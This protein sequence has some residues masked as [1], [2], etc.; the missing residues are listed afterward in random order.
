M[1]ILINLHSYQ[2]LI[3]SLSANFSE[4]KTMFSFFE[5]RVNTIRLYI[6][7]SALLVI[8]LKAM[9]TTQ[10]AFDPY[11]L[12]G[13]VAGYFLV[14]LGISYF[15]AGA[16]EFMAEL[17]GLGVGLI[18]VWL[19]ILLWGNNF[20][21]DFTSGYQILSVA[22]V[23]LFD[24]RRIMFWFSI[25]AG[26]TLLCAAFF[27]ISPI[28]QMWVFVAL[29]LAVFLV[30]NFIVASRVNTRSKLEMDL[31]H[32]L[33]IQ[34]AAIESNT[35]AILLVN[36]EGDYIKGNV[37][38]LQMW[39]VSA[40]MILQNLQAETE[41]QALSLV[42]DPKELSTIWAHRE[43]GLG[44]GELRQIAFKDGRMIELYWRPMINNDELIGRLWFFRD[45][46]AR[47]LH[48]TQLMATERQLRHQNEML[49]EF[50]SSFATNAGKLEEAF[51]EITSVSSELLQVDTVGV[52]FLDASK[53]EMRLELQFDRNEN[54][55]RGNVAVKLADHPDFFASLFK[56]RVFAVADTLRVESTAGFIEGKYSGKASALMHAQI[57]ARGECI[58]V[59][60]FECAGKIR[61][62]TL[63]EQN[64]AASLAD[65]VSV[66]L[67][68]EEKQNAQERL[69][70]SL[71]VLQAIFDLSETGIIVEDNDH[72]IL[73]YN[74]LY[75]KI[76][77]M[78]REFVD[79]QPYKVLVD[80]CLS[81]LKNSVAYEEGLEKLKVRPGMEYAGIMEFHDGRFIERYSKAIN[82][83]GDLMGRVWFYLD[84]TDRKRKENELINRNF[85][86]D[87]FVY[88]A[89][90]DLKA[91]LNSI[92]GLI[93]LIREEQEIDSILRYISMMDKSVKKL[94]EFIKQ[95][96]Q[97]S[98]DVRLKVVRKPIDFKEMVDDILGD[99][100]FME[101]A[102]RLAI[103]IEVE[104]QGAFYSDPVRLGIIMAN[105]L[106]NAIK[107]QDLKKEKST[108]RIHIV[109]DHAEAKCTFSDNGLGIKAEH[110]EKIFDLFF[111]ASIQASGTGLGLYITHNAVQKLGGK[112]V[113]DSEPGIG[114][115]F[116]LQLPNLAD[117]EAAENLERQSSEGL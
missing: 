105:L 37:A 67:A 70:N 34:E 103:E 73:N 51:R 50:A 74:E 28:D 22:S 98:Q 5:G 113:V 104:Q 83:G 93:S 102:A 71:A 3:I 18:A 88:R 61:E 14:I 65:L 117:E 13:S 33:T 72:R 9:V 96:T 23:L 80:H 84:I 107:Y 106:S 75:V 59:L 81:K 52:W 17:F 60:S 1:R 19:A 95:L 87:S 46:T 92:M 57:S 99:L 8:G 24:K 45:I 12:R 101:N 89:S 64:Y 41:M 49:M 30:G 111:R 108:L 110:L 76:W 90:H 68:T 44:I 54:A 53:S 2:L 109:A 63:E 91:P 43:G 66:S 100:K 97:F 27:S 21:Q 94:D 56:N 26:S 6:L 40:E 38:F 78:T 77:G 79:T 86:L 47:W 29:N 55:F 69:R 82:V 4:P 25:V 36:E 42:T 114:T 32:S 115:T 11:W 16:R 10:D 58:G 39:G 116:R 35:D 31:S 62:W 85:E 112:I 48:E 7:V 15:S 20:Y